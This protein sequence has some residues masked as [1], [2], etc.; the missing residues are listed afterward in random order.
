[1]TGN[2]KAPKALQRHMTFQDCVFSKV[3]TYELVVRFLGSNG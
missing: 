3:A 2:V 1:M